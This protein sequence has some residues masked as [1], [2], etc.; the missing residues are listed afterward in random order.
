[1]PFKPSPFTY[2][3]D[4]SLLFSIV[5]PVYNEQDNLVTLIEQIEWVMS[6]FSAQWEVLIINDGSTDK[7]QKILDD[8]AP[9]KPYLRVITFAKNAGQTSAFDAG[10]K[11]SRGTWVITLDG[12]GQNDPRDI[13]LLIE[14]AY[15]T[16]EKYDLIAGIRT[17]RRD[18]WYKRWISKGANSI[19]SWFL[20]DKSSDTGCS[21]K[22]Y[23][24]ECL[25]K[26]E[27]YKGMHRFMPALF[28]IEGFKVIEIPVHHRER[29]RGKSKYHLFNRGIS[30]ISDMFAVAWMRKRKLRYEIEKE[31]P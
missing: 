23:R 11:R 12:D 19:R 4:N 29:L 14:K 22:M 24:R 18:P 6:A 7:S 27:L 3:K 2:I 31:C 5:I 8:I 20:D 10:F 30:L 25:Q 9:K 16:D 1:M 15:G 13:P 26:I 21:L 28:H 17:L